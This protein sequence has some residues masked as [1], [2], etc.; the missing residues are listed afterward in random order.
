MLFDTIQVAMC[1]PGSSIETLYQSEFLKCAS[2]GLDH[3][4]VSD[5][6]ANGFGLLERGSGFLNLA[7]IPVVDAEG[8]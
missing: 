5:L 3:L 2:E 8:K 6:L 1:L 7:Q 4:R